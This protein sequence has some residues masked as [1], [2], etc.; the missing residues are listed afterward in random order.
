MEVTDA[1]SLEVVFGVAMV[2]GSDLSAKL[3]A[4]DS[5]SLAPSTT[6]NGI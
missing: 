6:S 4:Q 1:P 5:V 3:T 2:A